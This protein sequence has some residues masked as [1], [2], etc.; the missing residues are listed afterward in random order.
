MSLGKPLLRTVARR[1]VTVREPYGGTEQQLEIRVHVNLERDSYVVTTKCLGNLDLVSV[2]H[3]SL[4][5]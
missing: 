4:E 5:D 3:L 2:E 1:L